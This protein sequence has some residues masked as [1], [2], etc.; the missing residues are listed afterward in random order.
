MDLRIEQKREDILRIA[1]TYRAKNVRVFGSQCRN[2]EHPNSDL[3]LLVEF[4]NP[5]LL[6]R[7]AMKQDLEDLLGLKVDLLTDESLHPV[8]RDEILA[9]ARPL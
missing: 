3:D 6:D 2:E 7:I 5:N 4:E 8:L 1:T 9:E